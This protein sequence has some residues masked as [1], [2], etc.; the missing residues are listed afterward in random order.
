MLRLRC[1]VENLVM[2]RGES[3]LVLDLGFKG[4]E[5]LVLRRDEAVEEAERGARFLSLAVL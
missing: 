2:I 3:L 1:A 5:L 4:G